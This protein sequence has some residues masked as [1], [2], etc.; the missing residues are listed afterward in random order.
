LG[1]V[2]GEVADAVPTAD[3]D[4]AAAATNRLGSIMSV[5]ESRMDEFSQTLPELRTS[6]SLRQSLDNML[7]FLDT[8]ALHLK[9]SETLEPTHNNPS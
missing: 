4:V 2:K 5:T 1:G 8:S 6:S 7:A 9:K 3:V